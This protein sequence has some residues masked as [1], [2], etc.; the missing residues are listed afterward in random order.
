MC[1]WNDA[2]ESLVNVRTANRTCLILQ[3]CG[4]YWREFLALLVA[5]SYSSII[6]CSFLFLQ[7]HL[8]SLNFVISVFVCSTFLVY[9]ALGSLLYGLYLVDKD[10]AVP[11]LHSRSPSPDPLPAPI[12]RWPGSRG[13]NWTVSSN[14][15]Y[16]ELQE[17][18]AA[19]SLAS[20]APL[21][22]PPPSVVSSD[23]EEHPYAIIPD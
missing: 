4:R 12:S 5:L 14:P 9:L 3:C 20:T 6:L 19:A 15:W 2:R 23:D 8:S 1:L 7:N 10:L 18:G 21:T 13:G 11:S 16:F 17:T 22:A